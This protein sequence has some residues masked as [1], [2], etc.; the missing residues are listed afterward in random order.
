MKN[1]FKNR[2]FNLPDDIV[3]YIFKFSN[4]YKDNH[5]QCLFKLSLDHYWYKYLSTCFHSIR[6]RGFAKHFFRKR[7]E[8]LDIGRCLTTNDLK[9]L[10]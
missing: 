10:P 8:E 9:I 4:P 6:D 2:L 1:N 7:R 5:K 3:E